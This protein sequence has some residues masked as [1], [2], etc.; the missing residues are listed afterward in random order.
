MR[1]KAI[2]Q[3]NGRAYLVRDQEAAHGLLKTNAGSIVAV[4]EA[5]RGAVVAG[6]KL[7]ISSEPAG[8]LPS[9]QPT[10]PILAIGSLISL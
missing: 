5:N 8:G 9:G 4:S 1:V 10:G 3:P 2:R 7:A 6:A